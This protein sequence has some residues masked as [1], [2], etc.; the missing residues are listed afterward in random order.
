MKLEPA[1]GRKD[2]G[3]GVTTPR[4]SGR[5]LARKIRELRRKLRGPEFHLKIPMKFGP[6][7]GRNGTEAEERR[8]LESLLGLFAGNF[9]VRFGA[10]N[11]LENQNEIRAGDW[12]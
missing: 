12:T 11:P 5:A 3:L 9:V 2:E 8:L 7:I 6:A 10:P 1:N 4:K